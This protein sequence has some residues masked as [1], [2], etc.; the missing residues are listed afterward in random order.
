MN[1]SNI[2]YGV[3]IAGTGE[4][5]WH[6]PVLEIVDASVPVTAD[7]LTSYPGISQTDRYRSYHPNDFWKWYTIGHKVMPDGTWQANFSE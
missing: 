2:L 1:A 7:I 5:R 6:T 4:M 3:M